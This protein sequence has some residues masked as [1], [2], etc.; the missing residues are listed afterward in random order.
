MGA[1]LLL[2][3]FPAH[4]LD[5][6][7]GCASETPPFV[8]MKAGIGVSGY[9]VEYFKAVSKALGLTGEI[10]DLPWARCLRDVADGRIDVAVD[11]YDD[12]ERR[13][14]YLYSNPYYTLTPQVF[15]S[16]SKASKG[17][18]AKSAVELATL[19]G[20]GVHEYTYEHYGLDAKRMDRGAKSDKH[21]LQMLIAGR[22]DYAVEELEYIIGGRKQEKDWPNESTL[23]SYRPEWAKAPQ[24]HYLI[25]RKHPDGQKLQADLNRAIEALEK[26][27]ETKALR[28]SYFP[29]M[30][31]KR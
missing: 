5:R 26:S 21:L 2:A 14:Q 24:L 28:A 27:G 22:C 12:A 10:R 19:R 13:T 15:F 1:L 9:S 23:Q 20:C 29:G 31:V 18:P 8:L 7:T 6:L 11:A 3:A 4:A 30:G 25:G 16:A 17:L